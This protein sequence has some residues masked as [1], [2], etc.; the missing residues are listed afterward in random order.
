MLPRLGATYAIDLE[1]ISKPRAAYNTAEYSALGLPKAPAIMVGDD[2]VTA[3]KDVDD[4]TVEA[5]ICRHLGLPA[6]EA[7]RGKSFISRL[8]RR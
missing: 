8:F 4:Q 7:A 6:P 3:G 1:V 2:L 5:A